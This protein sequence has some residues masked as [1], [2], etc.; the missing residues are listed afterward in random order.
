M[1]D[2]ERTMTNVTLAIQGMTCNH[3]VMRVRKALADVP[4]VHKAVVT[5]EPGQAK[6]EY[7]D[8]A[9]T[10]DAMTAAVVKAGYSARAVG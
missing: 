6:V 9:S 3:C 5:L 4:G 8:S 10:A 7:D 1:G 2:R